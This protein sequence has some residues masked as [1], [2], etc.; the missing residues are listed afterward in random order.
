[1]G[2]RRQLLACSVHH[3]REYPVPNFTEAAV[4]SALILLLCEAVYVH[5]RSNIES[6][7]LDNATHQAVALHDYFAK[8]G[9]Y[10]AAGEVL[11]DA[12]RAGTSGTSWVAYGATGKLAQRSL[13]DQGGRCESVAQDYAAMQE[14]KFKGAPDLRLVCETHPDGVF[15]V[16]QLPAPQKG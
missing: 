14:A 13:G 3:V 9:R 8:T 6:D 5:H 4:A 7:I 2:E 15:L 1:M 11:P 16:L 12:P 10:P